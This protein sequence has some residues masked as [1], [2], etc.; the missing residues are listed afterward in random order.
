MQGY[1]TARRWLAM[2]LAALAGFIDATGFVASEQY[3][4]SFMSGNTTRLG[5]DLVTGG[6]TPLIP[7]LLILGFIVGVTAGA[8]LVYKVDRWRKTAVIALTAAL[9][10]GSAIGRASGSEAVFLACS[11]LAMGVINNAYSRN[12]E[13]AVGLTYMTGALVRFGQGLAARLSGEVREG[14]FLN[15]VLW[16]SLALGAVAGAAAAMRAPDIAP[17]MSA[18]LAFLL[19]LFAFLVERASPTS[20][21]S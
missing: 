11:V 18:S 19:V 4:V 3:F 20:Q 16:A 2:A 10:G 21:S 5:V 8:L 1:D 14:W 13:V 7:G 15:L 6:S 17:W 12:R 9:I